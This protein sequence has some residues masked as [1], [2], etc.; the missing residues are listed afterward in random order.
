MTLHCSCTRVA[1]DAVRLASSPSV[2]SFARSREGIVLA[3]CRRAVRCQ[4]W[5]IV[6]LRPF[7]PAGFLPRYATIPV[8]T[9]AWCHVALAVAGEFAARS[10][11]ID[12]R[13]NLTE[14]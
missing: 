6:G 10:P 14:S 12:S 4:Y 3:S 5:A 11:A 9:L 2:R 7:I 8:D 13:Q 1:G